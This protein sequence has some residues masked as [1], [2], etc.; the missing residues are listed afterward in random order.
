MDF[1]TI[2]NT[3]APYVGSGAIATAII[4]VVAIII[5]VASAIKHIKKEFTTTESE[6]LKAFKQ[7]IPEKLYI[8]IEGLVSSKMTELKEDFSAFFQ[9]D[10][11]EQIHAN[12]E[13]VKAIAEALVAM[14]ALPDSQ[15]SKISALLQI[16]MPKTTE[17]LKVD[18]LPV[19]RAEEKHEPAIYIE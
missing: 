14:R 4:A 3:I 2:Y 12:T 19:E 15:K 11:L 5:K 17:S 10:F 16:E 8:N 7:A 18:L 9:E 13:L 6:A 1:N